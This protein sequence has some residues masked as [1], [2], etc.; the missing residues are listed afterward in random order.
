MFLA[1]VHHLTCE[2]LTCEISKQYAKHFWHPS[3]IS[4]VRFGFSRVRFL[5]VVFHVM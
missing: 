2:I 3:I 5:R 1:L 4:H